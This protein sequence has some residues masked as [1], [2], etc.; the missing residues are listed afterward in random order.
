MIGTRQK[1]SGNPIQSDGR[2][3]DLRLAQLEGE[4][5]QQKTGPAGGHQGP[6]AQ[7]WKHLPMPKA[8]DPTY[9]DR[10]LLKE[11]VWEW[12][13][14]LYYY[15]GGA[16]G[17]AL[18]IGAA[19]QLDRSG[20]LD[21]LIR[22]CHWTGIIGT[23][24]S[25][26]LLTYD[27]GRPA[28]FLHM[29]R[30]FRPTSPM[31]MGVWILCGASP[32]AMTAALFTRRPGI[33]GRIGDCSGIASGVFGLGLATYTGVVLGNTAIPLWQ[34]S[35]SVLPI[36]F[37]ASAMASVGSMFD[38]LVE[39]RRARRITYTFGTIGRVAELAAGAVMQRQAAAVPAVGQPLKSGA[40]GALWKAA[41]ALTAG[42]LLAAVLPMRPRNKRM[43]A[44][45]LGI[46]G[47]LLMRYAVAQAGVASARDARASFHQQRRHP[48]K[49]ST[50]SQLPCWKT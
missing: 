10:P 32:A 8:D 11:P 5:A 39:D 13:I 21:D 22:R 46:L 27:L 12:V 34:Q 38:L 9:Y 23:A 41:T 19:A 37:G 43:A 49:S 26:G 44:G 45:V 18:A 15:V 50:V 2:D 31:N 6:A 36:L 42:S 14:P 17:A 33:W 7:E 29:L 24:L 40:G 35:R 28:R 25:A 4:A 30:V 1:E 16:A 20:K 48:A 47:S 3:I